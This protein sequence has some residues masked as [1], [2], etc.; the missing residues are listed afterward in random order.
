M[1]PDY[2]C[3]FAPSPEKNREDAN[4]C[5]RRNFLNLR[6]VLVVEKFSGIFLRVIKIRKNGKIFSFVFQEKS[7]K[8]EKL[9]KNNDASSNAPE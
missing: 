5:S 1:V 4:K 3:K 9:V 2:L 8:P 6:V 7:L